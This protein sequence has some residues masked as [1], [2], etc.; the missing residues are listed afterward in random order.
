MSSDSHKMVRTSISIPR[1]MKEKMDRLDINWSAFVR[2]AIGRKLEGYS[3]SDRVEAI[4]INE[5]LRR[6]A[7][8]GWD[9]A[10]VIRTWRDRRP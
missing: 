4:L 3:E 1:W 10:R 6:K 7:P 8:D 9:S 5:R 2:Q